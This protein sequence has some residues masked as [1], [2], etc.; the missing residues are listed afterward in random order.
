M[1]SIRN[2]K[3]EEIKTVK[4]A[5]KFIFENLEGKKGYIYSLRKLYFLAE[6][7]LN[8][9]ILI[10]SIDDFVYEQYSYPIKTDCNLN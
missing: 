1:A 7:N 9:T 8:N 6:N 2:N 3:T 10:K 4:E 5:P